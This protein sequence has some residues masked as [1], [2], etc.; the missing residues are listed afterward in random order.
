MEPPIVEELTIGQ[1]FENLSMVLDTMNKS[2]KAVGVDLKTIQKDV[3]KSNKTKATRKRAVVPDDGTE[4]KPSALQKPV[5]ISDELCK[6]LNFPIGE[7]YSRQQVTQSINLYVKTHNLQNPE[8]KRFILLDTC[9][10]GTALG[11]LLRTPD[12]PL[13][14]FNIQ[15]Y[16]KPHYPP[17]MKDQKAAAAAQGVVADSDVVE[18]VPVDVPDII[19][20]EDLKKKVV[21]RLVRTKT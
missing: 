2:M 21:K 15:R 7:L 12:Q 10:E 6:F 8:N 13:T 3:L 16:L 19:S 18:D 9:T 5:K 20:G 1:K 4:R 14:F 11:S 17:S